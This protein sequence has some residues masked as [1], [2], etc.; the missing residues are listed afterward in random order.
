VASGEVFSRDAEC[1]TADI[2]AFLFRILETGDYPALTPPTGFVCGIL[3]GY[4][5]VHCG[6]VESRVREETEEDIF[7]GEDE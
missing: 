7:S 1:L 6:E 2:L 5:A 4:T 3:F